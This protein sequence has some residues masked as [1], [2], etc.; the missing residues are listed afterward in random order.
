MKKEEIIENPSVFKP[1]V[2]LLGAGASLAAL[3]NGDANKK[4]LPL[5]NNLVEVIQLTTLLE[6]HKINPSGNFETIYGKLR[7]N[8]LKKEIESRVFQ[9]FNSLSLPETTTIYDK[10]LLS[11]RRKDAVFTFNWDPFLFDAYQRNRNVAPL[12]HIFFLHGNVRIGACETCDNWGRKSGHCS[13][14]NQKFEDI[15]L[16]YPL[17]KKNYFETNQYTALSWKSAKC[18]FSEAFTIT[19]FGYSA[20]TS[21]QEAVELLKKA[22]FQK[23]N[24]EFEHIEIIDIICNEQLAMRWRPFTPTHH[25]SATSNFENSRLWNW[26]RRS[27]ESLFYPMT[28]GIPCEAFPLNLKKAN[29]LNELQTSMKEIAKF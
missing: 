29:D 7:N 26:P 11:L 17:K 22:W 21:D 20:P 18:W 2:V 1:H 8:D 3:P 10:I 25:F 24:R 14:C 4:Q 27:C 19:I 23:S 6:K 16:L 28:K 15:P 13:N 12:P 9:Y 5:M